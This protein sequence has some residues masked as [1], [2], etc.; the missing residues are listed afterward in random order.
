MYV[1]GEKEREK[2][3]SETEGSETERDR[4]SSTYAI[5]NGSH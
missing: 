1:E 3:G 2:E 5:L 4:E